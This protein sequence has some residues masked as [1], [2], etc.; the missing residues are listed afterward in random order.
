MMGSTSKTGLTP[1]FKEKPEQDYL[2]RVM[3]IESN[4]DV[5]RQGEDARCEA[6]EA[7]VDKTSLKCS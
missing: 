1:Q 4:G 7:F 2:A 3:P 5:F 6:S